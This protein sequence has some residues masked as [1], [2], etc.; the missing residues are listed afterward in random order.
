MQEKRV[1]ILGS[2]GSLGG[3][4]IS[5]F[6]STYVVICPLPRNDRRL[7]DT[8]GVTWAN[9]VLDVEDSG[10]IT[11]MLYDTHPD[12]IVNCVAVT[13]R[14]RSFSNHRICM[15]V[16]GAFP[17]RLAE[18]A[19]R[20]KAY[21]VHISTDG[22]FSGQKGQYSETDQPDPMD[23]YGYTKLR[24]ELDA[25]HCLTLRTTFYGVFPT[26]TGLLNWL[27]SK[28]GHRIEGYAN[29]VFS[30]ISAQQLAAITGHI[31]DSGRRPYGIYHAGGEATTKFQFLDLVRSIWGLR[32]EIVPIDWP[33]I[34][35]S[36]NSS[37]FWQTLGW[38]APSHQEMIE[39]LRPELAPATSMLTA[40]EQRQYRLGNGSVS[41][42]AQE[43][44]GR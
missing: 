22:V 37:L 44:D 36:L 19:Q 1:M 15:Q 9:T 28:N 31:I 11:R 18:A 3:Y 42:T 27:L 21:V 7:Q 10:A 26:G 25:D 14:S 12:V 38:A 5:C 32:V 23:H 34:D 33:V 17:H 24:G 40:V 16:N 41:P 43:V 8:H 20:I 35:R 4:L 29:Y 30:P 6:R 2:T 13:P 39:A